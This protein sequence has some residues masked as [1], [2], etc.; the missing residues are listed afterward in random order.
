M[1]RSKRIQDLYFGVICPDW[2]VAKGGRGVVNLFDLCG[3]RY[4]AARYRLRESG[5]GFNRAICGD[6][7]FF[8]FGD[9]WSRCEFEFVINSFPEK[10]EGSKMS[11]FDMYVTPNKQLLLNMID[12]CSEGS[13]RTYIREWKKEHLTR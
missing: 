3:I 11:I 12:E 9:V 8:V 1:A 13:A 10:G 5:C 4:Y 7:L 2:L 6:P